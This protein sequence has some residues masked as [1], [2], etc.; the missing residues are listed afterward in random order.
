MK[1]VNSFVNFKKNKKG[2][3]PVTILVIGVFAICS[4]ALLTFFIS[5][6]KITNSFV[7]FEVMEKMNS[8]IDEYKY[9]K[10]EG[11]SEKKIQGYY[12]ILEENGRSYLYL[13]KYSSGIFGNEK[14]LLF[15][16]RYPVPNV[17]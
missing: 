8:Q 14:K 3:V 6:F 1:S 11:V 9:Y 4:L 17:R 12:R 13:E 16:V 10:S 15:S 7:S 5:D 2:D